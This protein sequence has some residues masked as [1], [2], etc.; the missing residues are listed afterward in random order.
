[1]LNIQG[2]FFISY[3][4]LLSISIPF[5]YSRCAPIGVKPPCHV[6]PGN[7][8]KPF[9]QCCHEIV[10]PEKQPITNTLKLEENWTCNVKT[11]DKTKCILLELIALSTID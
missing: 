8:S 9:G 1:M 4:Y 3:F 5:I 6:G 7:L 10:C 11:I 2:N